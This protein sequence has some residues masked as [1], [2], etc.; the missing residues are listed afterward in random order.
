M[1]QSSHNFK[2]MKVLHI[3]INKY[4][5]TLYVFNFTYTANVWNYAQT[6]SNEIQQVENKHKVY[7]ID[8]FYLN[9]NLNQIRWFFN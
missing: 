6:Y 9:Q 5:T 2:S 4:Y 7:F 1:V 3:N 8:T